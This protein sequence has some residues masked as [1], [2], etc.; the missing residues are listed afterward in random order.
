[1]SRLKIVTFFL[2]IVSTNG[3]P[4]C[5]GLISTTNTTENIDPIPREKL[6]TFCDS[7]QYGWYVSS[8]RYD[9]WFFYFD[10][11]TD[12]TNSSHAEEFFQNVSETSN[13][14]FSNFGGVDGVWVAYHS[15]LPP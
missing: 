11:L 12:L 8:T 1:M 2:I 5:D 3:E 7:K 6:D 10:N 15:R 14:T 13:F 4:N 9:D